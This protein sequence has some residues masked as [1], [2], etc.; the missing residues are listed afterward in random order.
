VAGHR[1]LVI[2]QQGKQAFRPG[3]LDS[4]TQPIPITPSL[5]LFKQHLHTLRHVY[6]QEP[7]QIPDHRGES[8][9][10]D[11]LRY[12]FGGEVAFAKSDYLKVELDDENAVQALDGSAEQR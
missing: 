12:A 4:L 10:K 1:A 6:P 3:I 2:L 5:A 7:V 8:S 9:E 11:G